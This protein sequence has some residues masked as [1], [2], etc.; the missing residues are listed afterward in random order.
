MNCSNERYWQYFVE[1]N[2]DNL[3]SCRFRVKNIFTKPMTECWL[4]LKNVIYVFNWK[5]EVSFSKN[6]LQVRREFSW[7]AISILDVY[8]CLKQVDTLGSFRDYCASNMK[9]W[10]DTLREKRESPILIPE[11]TQYIPEEA[12]EVSNQ[13]AFYL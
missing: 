8:I 2:N 1:T 12:F 4:Q 13:I 9:I 10:F 6:F 3:C 5:I 11:I 7:S